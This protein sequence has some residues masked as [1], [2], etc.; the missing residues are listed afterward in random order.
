MGSKDLREKH[1]FSYN[2]VFASAWNDLAPAC[3]E[4]ANAALKWFDPEDLTDA[5]TETVAVLR[6]GI[7]QRYRDILK[8]AGSE[9]GLNI[10]MFGLENQTTVDWEMPM[11]VMMYD[12]MAY[13]AQIQNRQDGQNL[14][15]IFTRVL[16]FGYNKRWNAPRR[17]SDRCAIPERFR[18]HFQDYAVDVIEMAWLDDSQID[19]LGGDIKA[20]AI[21]LRNLRLNEFRSWPEIEIKHVSEMLDLFAAITG[22][23]RFEEMKL[24]FKDEG[25]VKMCEVLQKYDEKLIREGEKRGEKRGMNEKAVSVAKKL[26][27]MKMNNADIADVTGLPL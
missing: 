17:L 10:A 26:I 25:S 18:A 27:G 24:E 7:S 1:L 14:V 21:F 2:D 8:Y 3:A 13:L 20:L 22:Q 15:P 19:R 11:R 23:S 16:Y 12:A 4:N 5:P 6:G 9:L